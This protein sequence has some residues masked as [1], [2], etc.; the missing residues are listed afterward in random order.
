MFDF[1]DSDWFNITLEIVF[2]VL[3]IFDIIKYLQTKKREYLLNIVLTIGFGV[4]ALMPY[5]TSYIEWSESEKN[6]LVSTCDT[7]QNQTLCRCLDDAIF[8]NYSHSEYIKLD[9]NATD[10]KEFLQD[11]TK[12]CQ[13]DSWF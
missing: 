5:Y 8:K 10:F 13:D 6:S 1:L 2:L 7:E 11:A 3:I 4:W 12:E 9:K